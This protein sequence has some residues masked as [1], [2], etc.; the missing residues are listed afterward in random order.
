MSLACFK[1]SKNFNPWVV[2]HSGVSEFALVSACTQAT[3]CQP[4]FSGVGTCLIHSIGVYRRRSACGVR[5]TWRR[6]RRWRATRR[7]P[8]VSRSSASSQPAS[9][10]TLFTALRTTAGDA[11]NNFAGCTYR[12]FLS[13][14]RATVVVTRSSARG[15]ALGRA[16]HFDWFCDRVIYPS[17]YQ[18]SSMQVNGVSWVQ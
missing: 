11:L 14:R 3:H 7:P 18:G 8:R 12:H 1:L 5:S 10:P 9:Q 17:G 2:V 16:L 6:R 13:L 15:F 4:S